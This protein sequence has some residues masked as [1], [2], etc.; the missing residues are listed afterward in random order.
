MEP[1]RD[2][3][4]NIPHW[5]EYSNYGV[6]ALAILVLIYG[7]YRRVRLWRIGQKEDRLDQIPVRVGRLLS[8]AVAQVRVAAERYP[9]FMH[10]FIFWG[11]VVLFVGTALATID[12]DFT[13]PFLGFKLLKGDF[14][15]LYELSLDIFGV[16]F[17]V[18]LLLAVY[19]RYVVR[20]QRLNGDWDFIF[21]LSLLLLINVTGFVVEGLRLAAVQPT[22]GLW[23]PAGYALAQMFLGLGAGESLIHT[24][25]FSFWL[26]HFV[27]V[28]LLIASVP[29][30]NLFHVLTTPLN[31]FFA[32]LRPA[33]ALQP[34]E[35]IEEAEILGAGKIQEF[36]W[37]QLLDL[38]ACTE[39][40]RCQDVCPAWQ[41]GMP[42]SPKRLILDLRDH[43][44]DRASVLLSKGGS[45]PEEGSAL[46]GEVIADDTLWACTTCRACME[47]CP[48][49][50]EHVDTIVDMR[51]W[52]SLSEGRLP[53][54][55]ATSLRNLMST[56][57]PWGQPPTAR[58]EWAAGLE[59][60]RMAEAREAD[61][62]YWVGCA[63]SYDARNQKVARA[64]AHL[65]QTA[66]VNFAILGEE[67]SCNGEPARRL[68]EEYLFQTL[69]EQNIEI[70]KQYRFEKIITACPHCF[71]TLANEYPQ[72][73]GQ[74]EVVH[75]SQFILDLIREGKLSPARKA[76]CSV[77][78][79][80][81]CYLGRYNDIFDAPREVIVSIPG[82]QMREMA[83]ARERGLCCGGG[84]G[85]MWVEVEGDTR[86]NELRLDEAMSVKPDVLGTA[87]PFC[88]FMFDLAAKVK[89]LEESVQ[90]K[91]IA[92]LVSEAL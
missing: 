71:N 41:T 36:T 57:N 32:S 68:G 10:L 17:L 44:S 37:K 40:G 63:G 62:L 35:N 51:R 46:V 11:F 25:H 18:G 73:G 55:V 53:S 82:A 65:L 72:F 42:L 90:L 52:L 88:M 76:D 83:R 54:T 86:I 30:T 20:P 6:A 79:H 7:F 27:I 3:F 34:I 9:G 29:Y 64:F 80:D 81:S 39:C 89:G 56:G 70:L 48:V 59:V 91:D 16:L 66:G 4:W 67:E 15:L 8:Y 12:Y 21:T 45:S 5:A 47:E 75:H 58:A 38:D 22:W 78:Y 23:S 1:F 61:V 13:L 19:R 69:A 50:V 77:A 26:F 85:G 49:L 24:L 43:L 14:Y 74:F 31:V 87:C 60:P 33:G 28:V 84:G 92:E 2:T